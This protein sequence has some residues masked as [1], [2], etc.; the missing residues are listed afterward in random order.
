MSKDQDLITVLNA[1]FAEVG[2]QLV[3]NGA[4]MSRIEREMASRI[5]TNTKEIAVIKK[6]AET[7]ASTVETATTEI[8]EL[9]K[10]NKDLKEN[11][12]RMEGIMQS[13]DKALRKVTLSDLDSKRRRYRK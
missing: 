7:T 6:V 2:K 4:T 11:M 1:K 5:S 12:H 8:A 10:E 13:Q 9:K 3:H